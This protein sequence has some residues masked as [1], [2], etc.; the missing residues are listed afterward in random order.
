MDVDVDGGVME[1][2]GVE[3]GIEVGG[4]GVMALEMVE[5]VVSWPGGTYAL[6]DVVVVDEE[7][8]EEVEM[9]VVISSPGGT[10]ALRE[11][12]VV[13]LLVDDVT[14]ILLEVVST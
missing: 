4:V 12:L 8:D 10:F 1:V 2:G 11:V 13:S 7:S 3:V 9:E 5:L 6:S 14:G